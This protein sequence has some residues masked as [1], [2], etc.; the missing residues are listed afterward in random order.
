MKPSTSFTAN[1]L[2]LSALCIALL[3][4]CGGSGEFVTASSTTDAFASSGVTTVTATPAV[5]DTSSA[6]PVSVINTPVMVAAPVAEART[7]TTQ[8]MTNEMGTT[9]AVVAAPTA[10]AGGRV[11][12][13]RPSEPKKMLASLIDAASSAISTVVAVFTDPSP[14]ITAPVVVAAPSVVVAAPV[15]STPPLVAPQPE[16]LPIILAPAP[17]VVV[18]GNGGTI[19]DVKFENLMGNVQT[20]VPVT[21]GQVFV[22]GAVS[23]TDTLAGALENGSLIPMQMDVKATYADG[24]VR[25]AVLSA[26]LPS[27]AIGQ[28]LNLNLTKASVSQAASTAVTPAELLAAGFSTNVS[29]TVDGQLYT[30][31][32]DELLKTAQAKSWLSGRIANEWMVSAPF[33]N[34]AGVAHPHLTAR[35]D[36]RAYAGMNK[37]KVD[38]VVENDWAYEAAPRNFKYDAQIAVGG[39]TVYTKA[40]LNHYHHARWKKTFW[41]G[42]LPP[43]NVK[44]NAAYLIATRAVPNYDQSASPSATTLSR[45]RTA[46][47][48]AVSEPMGSGM[49][50]PYM[51]QTGGRP[52]IGILPGWAVSYLLSMDKDAKTAMLGTADLAGS[53]SNHYRDR[54]TDRV[55]SMLDFPYM[56]LLGREGD[57]FNPVTKKYESFPV[58]GGDC[59]T[60]LTA[61]SSHEP[62]TAYLPYIIT[63][64]HYYLEELQFW[65]MF[66]MF[67]HNPGYRDASKGL[68]KADQIRGQAWSLRTLGDA[69]FITPD[70]DPLKAQFAG[71]LSNNLDWYNAAYTNN[72][73]PDNLLGAITDANALVYDGGV[74]LAPWQDDFF[75]MAIGHVAELGYTKAAQLLKWKS[76]F[77]VNRMAAPGYCWIDA[78]IYKL[79]VRDS[80][81]G[82][83]YTT[84]AQ[85]YKAS[86]TAAIAA[87][88][89][90][91]PAMATAM[92]L[93]TGEMA[94]YANVIDGYPAYLQPALAYSVDSGNSLGRTAWTTFQA[95]AVKPNYADGAQF[96]IL[97]R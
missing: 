56:T 44:H 51:P 14:A 75:T 40:G 5:N 37:A 7:N 48:G 29:L 45:I 32:A 54:N 46:F 87:T 68:V 77:P 30:A 94:G 88:A 18:Q 89:C 91:S 23:A 27:L 55:I 31:S 53:Y 38:V 20:N 78:S 59:T 58:C 17:I 93:A 76:S 81:T 71:F 36:V 73:N 74:G 67:Q 49:A 84:M 10:R 64:D 11:A 16:P 33:R 21:F 82:A 66:N 19:T 61:D 79:K 69:A 85:A 63:G 96:A 39:S 4:A 50:A 6:Q 70:A 62:N 12:L 2:A 9:P 43:V 60:L 42:G 83:N 52:D 80:A 28:T 35:F 57:T 65:A 92:G 13:N 95:R 15:V 26:A 72:A 86:E 97:P 8:A 25:H 41:W 47:T 1:R 24:S 22:A 34:A 90:G 3:S